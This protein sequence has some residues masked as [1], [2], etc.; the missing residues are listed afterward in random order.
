MKNFKISEEQVNEILEYINQRRI[1]KAKEV[2]SKLEE[3]KVGKVLGEKD[4]D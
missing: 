2:L 1:L 4:N 3:M